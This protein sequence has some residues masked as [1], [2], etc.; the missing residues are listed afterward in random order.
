MCSISIKKKQRGRGRGRGRG[1]DR[2]MMK[3]ASDFKNVDINYPKSIDSMENVFSKQKNPS[4][5]TYKPC[6]WG[7]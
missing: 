1:R 4:S 5:S 3:L 2:D 7:F 6:F